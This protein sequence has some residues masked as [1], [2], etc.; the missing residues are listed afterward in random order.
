MT[1]CSL[2]VMVTQLATVHFHNVYLPANS[3]S[4]S[5]RVHFHIMYLP[6]NKRRYVRMGRYSVVW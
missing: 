2:V 6:T 4:N 3:N 5:K 1:L